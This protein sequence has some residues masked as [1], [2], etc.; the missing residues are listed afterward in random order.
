MHKGDKYKHRRGG[1]YKKFRNFPSYFYKTCNCLMKQSY[2]FER[3]LFSNVD[4]ITVEK[5]YRELN[6]TKQALHSFL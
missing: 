1:R 2:S 5:Q 3:F 6:D 4:D